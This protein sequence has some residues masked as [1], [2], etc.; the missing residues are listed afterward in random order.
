MTRRPARTVGLWV[1]L[2][3]NAFLA[4][5]V[6][7]HLVGAAVAR[8]PRHGIDVAIA[9]MAAVLPPADAARFRATLAAERSRYEPARRQVEQAQLGVAHAIGRE[10]FDAA[11]VRGAMQAWR[12]RWPAFAG[13]F[14]ASILDAV[15][16]LSPAGRARLSAYMQHKAEVRQ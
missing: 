8:G 6:G 1:S 13:A 11:R 7:A 16:T 3:L 5:L 12:E 15:G 10:P 2:A 4:A 9:R 14:S